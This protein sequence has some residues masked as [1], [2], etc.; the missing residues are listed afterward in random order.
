MAKKINFDN[1]LIE[2]RPN[3]APYEGLTWFYTFGG[4]MAGWARSEEEATQQ[5]EN[6]IKSSGKKRARKIPEGGVYV[7]NKKAS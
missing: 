5:I 6:W 3:T 7:V 1:I 2:H 4:D